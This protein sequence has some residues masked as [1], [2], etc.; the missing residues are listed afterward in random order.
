MSDDAVV[1]WLLDSDPSL[2][3]QVERDLL[4]AS[5][6]VWQR[7]RAQVAVT[8][9]GAR[10][11]S[12]QDPDGRWA[13][14]AFFPADFDF[15]TQDDTPGQP[16]TATTWTLTTLREW[17]TDAAALGDTADR[18][19]VSA[20][21]E[22]D[23]LPYWGGEVDVCINAMTLLNGVW[24]G[25]DMSALAGWFA[26]HQLADG[27]WNCEWVDGS[28]RSSFHSTLNAVRG[29]LE[30]E[31]R[32]GDT[33]LVE[34]RHRGEE[35]LLARRLRRRLS[36]GEQVGP[37]TDLIVYPYRA[38]FSALKA[39]DHVTAVAA[40]D[41]VRPDPRAGDSIELVRAARQDDG[42]W[43]QGYHFPGEVW[44]PLDVPVGEPSRWITFLALRALR[45]WDAAVG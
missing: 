23:D 37:W 33:A 2:R 1:A 13:G 42:R 16:Y 14:G 11:L 22:Y 44:F 36:T 19:E 3:W 27:G 10:L 45:R 9:D 6:E 17:G 31:Q 24:L 20:R 35:Y 43:L 40:H 29:L 4:D 34:V 5:D 30:Y 28:V 25:R 39:I 26:E 7:T 12:C 21:W 38:P 32:T 15:Q 8:G 18:L 41:G